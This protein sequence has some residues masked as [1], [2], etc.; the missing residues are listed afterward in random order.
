MNDL[1]VDA[2]IMRGT[3]FSAIYEKP[4]DLQFD[5]VLQDVKDKA[6]QL[7]DL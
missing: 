2:N 3:E 5:T 4:S 7:L 1:K 6:E